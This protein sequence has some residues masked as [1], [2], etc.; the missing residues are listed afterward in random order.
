MTTTKPLAIG[1]TTV[2]PGDASEYLA[3]THIMVYDPSAPHETYIKGMFGHVGA[4]D[5]RESRTNAVLFAHAK[6][7][8]ELLLA[9]TTGCRQDDENQYNGQ[10]F[11]TTTEAALQMAEE[12]LADLNK[13]IG[14]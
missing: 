7:M 14:E 10:I 6:V 2:E 1:R 11:S 8:R 13:L 4:P 12:M 5:E 9:I 3:G